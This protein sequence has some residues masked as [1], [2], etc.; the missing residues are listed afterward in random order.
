MWPEDRGIL[1]Q[2]CSNESHDA[3][4]PVAT[5]QNS[6]SWYLFVGDRG[7]VDSLLNKTMVIIPRQLAVAAWMETAHVIQLLAMTFVASEKGWD[8]IALLILLIVSTVL[9]L[10]FRRQS[11]TRLFCNSNGVTV[12]QGSFEF[13]SRTP[14][15]DAIH[16]FS[17][18]SQWK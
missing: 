1:G 4:M 10:Q 2:W 13:S 5:H 17:G 14:M 16:R 7:I 18:C 15:L 8:G 3:C 6:S 12:K 9:E 11:L